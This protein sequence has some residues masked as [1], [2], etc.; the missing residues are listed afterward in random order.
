MAV[1]DELVTVLGVNLAAGAMNKLTSF[2][3]SVAGITQK[4]T[5]LGTIVTASSA[6][7]GL[8]INNAVN[9]AAELDK[10]SQQTNT[11]TDALQEWGYAA[12]QVGGDAKAVQQDLAKLQEKFG[13]T[14]KSADDMLMQMSDRL[15]KLSSN[16]AL[17][18][19]KAFGLSDDTILLLRKGREGVEE[20]RKEAHKLGGV[21]PASAIK[22][23]ADFKKSLAELQFAIKGITQQVALATVPALEKVV[24]GFK[25]WIESNREWISLGLSALFE[26]VIKGFERFVD[27]LRQVG[28]VFQPVLDYVKQ[29]IPDMEGAEVVSRL[30]TGAL[31]GL[32]VILSPLLIKLALIGAAVIAA[33]IIFEDFFTYLEG[34]ESVIG[35]L[36][37]A[38]AERFPELYEALTRIGDFLK[39]VLIA[40][41]EGLKT[42]AIAVGSALLEVFAA[43]GDAIGPLLLDV[44]N[45]FD[46]FDE[47]FPALTAALETVGNVIKT[48]V[49]GA[50]NILITV[51]KEV[52]GFIGDLLGL[53]GDVIAKG[54]E[55]LNWAAEKLGFGGSDVGGAVAELD[56][57]I[58][59]VNQ[60]QMDAGT[61]GG[62]VHSLTGKLDDRPNEYNDNK[63]VTI[64]VTTSDSIVAG[65]QAAQAVQN[66]SNVISPG[67]YAPRSM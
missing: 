29:F 64:Q 63:T 35:S 58:A 20:L 49:V 46:T 37:D 41:F 38:F 50:F 54:F 21:I 48:V 13:A 3:N 45:F 62:Q 57:Q 66:Q 53:L 9:Q 15:S 23:A 51:V 27:V 31:T 19:G 2:K 40:G 59:N 43:I 26:G 33:T 28:T 7:I 16:R 1:V 6:G 47:R 56:N 44:V 67:Q 8:F 11:S 55:F 17:A 12:T 34:G 32:L 10:L 65:N 42:V 39:D 25:L 22:R 36:F 52:I 60:M 5:I 14:G 18:T 24:Q 30:V 61:A 4:L